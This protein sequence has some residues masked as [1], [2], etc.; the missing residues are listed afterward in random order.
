MEGE[1]WIS[2]LFCV[3]GGRGKAAGRRHSTS[4]NEELGH[5][6]ITW[7]V[8]RLRTNTQSYSGLYSITS[9]QYST[10]YQY[11]GSS[12]FTVNSEQA[13]NRQFTLHNVTNVI[14]DERI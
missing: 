12:Q 14:T 9:T 3:L 5:T 11:I 8:L 2:H 1:A 13:T 7:F 10:L 4:S 6:S